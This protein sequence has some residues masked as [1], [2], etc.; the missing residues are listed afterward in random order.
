MTS[1]IH[2][3]FE[4]P[5]DEVPSPEVVQLHKVVMT[6]AKALMASAFAEERRKVL[7]NQQ[8]PTKNQ[9]EVVKHFRSSLNE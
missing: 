9:L 7:A 6:E 4:L 3:V 5:P 1:L 2:T 8:P